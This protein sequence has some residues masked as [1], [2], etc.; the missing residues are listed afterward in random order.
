MIIY[1]KCTI[2]FTDVIIYSTSG[3]NTNSRPQLK[4][5]GTARLKGGRFWDGAGGKRAVRHD[6][7]F[8]SK[9]T[10]HRGGKL[11]VADE[12]IRQTFNGEGR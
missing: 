7:T 8:H 2:C 12:E 3:G 9:E 1:Q 6:I 10:V 5:A 4:A 11:D